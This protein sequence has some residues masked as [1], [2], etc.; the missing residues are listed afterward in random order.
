MK[1]IV[2]LLPEVYSFYKL[3][4]VLSQLFYI[5]KKTV[6]CNWNT[7]SLTSDRFW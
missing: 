2:G 5:S 7:C 6:S 4:L 3:L 1:I